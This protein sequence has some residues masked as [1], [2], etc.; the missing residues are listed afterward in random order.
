MCFTKHMNS[1][2]GNYCSDLHNPWWRHE[3]ETFCALLV[4]CAG[5]HLSPVT[6]PHKG[7]WCRALMFSLICA[8]TNFWVTTRDA[9][10][11][12]CHRTHYDR[13]VT[14]VQAFR[15][16]SQYIPKDMLRLHNKIQWKIHFAVIPFMVIISIQNLANPIE[17][18][19]DSILTHCGLVTTYG[20]G[21]LGQ[22]SLR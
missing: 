5:I 17:W 21:D 3:M 12:R 16:S 1:Q 19:T 8:W 15:K 7:Q 10:D 14:L 9:G 4:L 18:D 2:C 20:D 6:S 13:N 11:L 22:H